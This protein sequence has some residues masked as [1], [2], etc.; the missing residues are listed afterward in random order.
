M[1]KDYAKYY[2][3]FYKD[4]PY[5]KEIDFVY[6][7][8]GKPKSIL[9]IGCGTAQ[10]WEYYPKNVELIGIDKSEEMIKQSKFKKNIYNLDIE[11][12]DFG[13]RIFDCVTSLFDALNYI[14]KHDWWHTLP[15][16]KG[17]YFIFDIWDKRKVDKN[18][19]KITTKRVG[20]NIR[21]ILPIRDKDV[22][23]LM[24]MV[25][26][27]KDFVLEHHKMYLYSEQ[28]LKNFCGKEFKIVDKKE[29]KTWQTWYKL[30]RL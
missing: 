2:N 29:T 20:D 3:K 15:I 8:A 18:G 23:D 27:D 4:K 5:K 22:V 28:D 6:K 14:P 9:D 7:W 12:S 1:F 17:G 30:Q 26:A 25:N 10:Y 13:C 11:K 19:F 24:I 21:T 16:K